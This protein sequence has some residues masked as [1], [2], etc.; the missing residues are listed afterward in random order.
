MTATTSVSKSNLLGFVKT[1][2]TLRLKKFE[3]S[4]IGNATKNK[5]NSL[6]MAEQDYR[7]AILTNK[8]N[9]IALLLEGSDLNVAKLDKI[10]AE[11]KAEAERELA[12]FETA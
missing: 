11:A 3:A 8:N 12:E 6:E 7:E 10:T 2:N 1:E 5:L 4:K 9:I